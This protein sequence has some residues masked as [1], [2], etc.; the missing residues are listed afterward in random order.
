MNESSAR[1]WMA[2]VWGM[3]L[4][5]WRAGMLGR[6]LNKMDAWAERNLVKFSKSKGKFLCLGRNNPMHGHQL[7]LTGEAAVLRKGT[8]QSW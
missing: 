4:T 7:G 2:P 5:C 8:L 3:Q 1:L 6:D